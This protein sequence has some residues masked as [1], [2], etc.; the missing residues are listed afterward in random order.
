MKLSRRGI[1][2][3][4]LMGSIVVL[5]AAFGGFA[6]AGQG[7]IGYWPFDTGGAD[8]SGG[9]RDLT[10]ANGAGLANGLFGGALDLHD[11]GSQYA[12]RPGDDDIYD[13]GLGDFTIQIW[14]NFNNKYREQT[15]I[16]KFWGG[17]GPGW[18]L[19]KLDGDALHF[20]AN[21]TVAFSSASLA[22][23]SNVWHQFVLRRS[24]E[25]YQIIYDGAVVAE[26]AGP[27][28]VPDTTMPLVIGK[29]NDYDGR[30]FAVDGRIDET[31]I[32]SRALSDNEISWLYNQGKGN[33]VP[34]LGNGDC[35]DDD[36]DHDDGNDH[37]HKKKHRDGRGKQGKGHDEHDE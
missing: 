24:G 18:T 15:L 23:P 20:W 33:A 26:G 27:G 16:E 30:D 12:A 28:A 4:I 10:L 35:D 17:G 5:C 2:K 3:L 11:N 37:H 19:T 14:A 22:I 32:W 29:R 13:F 36:N 34:G 9:G 25:L 31:A 21:P 7:L 1:R 8:Q 6:E